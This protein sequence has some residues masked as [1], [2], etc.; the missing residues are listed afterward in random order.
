MNI[1]IYFII[2]LHTVITCVFGYIYRELDEKE[3]R[4]H[5]SFLFV[6]ILLAFELLA[7]LLLISIVIDK[8][9]R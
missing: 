1:F 7:T 5:E 6:T 9:E 8:W 4:H 2:A 3:E